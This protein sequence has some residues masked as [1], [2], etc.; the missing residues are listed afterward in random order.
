MVTRRSPAAGL[1]AL[2]L[3]LLLALAACGGDDG[4]AEQPAETQP[5][6]TQPAET[7]PAE[8]QPA[9]EPAEG[10]GDLLAQ[11]LEKGVLT[12]STDPAYPPQSFLNEETSEYEG[13]DIDVATEI[14]KRLGV[15]IAWEAPSW[16]TIIAG[17]WNG[18]W[19]ISVGSMTITPERAEVL[20]FTPP[21]YFT[22]AAVAVH[23]DN[24]TVAE[25]ADLSGKKV[26][27][28]GGCT[29][30]LYLQGTLELAEDPSGEA[31]AIESVVTDPEIVTYDTDST[32]IQDLALGDGRRL[33]GVI[34]ALPTLQ[35]AIKA[36]TA[37][38]IV[39]SPVFFE[40]LSVA[41]DRS[42][43]LDP[44]SLVERISEIVEEMHADGT[45][46]ELSNKWYGV[47]LTV[48]S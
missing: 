2:I 28:C 25:A 26:G 29:Y 47:D 48:R 1:A 10:D 43:T 15:E 19:D 23:A 9:E 11:V 44:T 17:N 32:A 18:R 8:T 36:G 3:A 22:P 46:S 34:S 5:A 7:Q 42:S 40:P 38:K 45:L 27:V 12:V 37:I 30:D 6:E 24:T 39:G 31:V 41:I 13:F 16:D 14:A 35:E 21:Y 4:T 20:H 33:D